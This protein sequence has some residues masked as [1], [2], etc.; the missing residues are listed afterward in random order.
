MT[1]ETDGHGD[2]IP[3]KLEVVEETASIQK[4]EVM[5]GKVR[6]TT[7]TRLVE[8]T[9]AR[10][11]RGTE[12]DIHRVSINR[13]LD[14]N[15]PPPEPRTEGDT[16]IIPVFEEIAVVETRLVLKEELHIVQR[17][18]TETV[19]IPVSLRKQ[20]ASIERITPQGDVTKEG[21]RH[22]D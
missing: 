16:T 17:R 22:D 21:T 5:T 19:E 15:E 7:S 6:V 1:K 3:G 18:T 2:T 14:H 9:E 8:N 20:S 12:T 4:R 11:L 10:D 13:M